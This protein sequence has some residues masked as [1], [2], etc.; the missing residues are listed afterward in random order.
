MTDEIE[1]AKGEDGCGGAMTVPLYSAA[2]RK[3]RAISSRPACHSVLPRGSPVRIDA[4]RFHIREPGNCRRNC[5]AV[6]TDKLTISAT[7]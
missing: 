7:A 5:R 2:R 3:L 4:M 6:T 1:T